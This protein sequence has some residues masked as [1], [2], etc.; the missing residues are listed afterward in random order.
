MMLLGKPE[1]LKH[2]LF[3]PTNSPTEVHEMHNRMQ[4]L[5]NLLQ[6]KK[7]F[8]SSFFIIAAISI[9]LFYSVEPVK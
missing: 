5:T 2:S 9:I 4:K 6:N 1:G 7:N 3:I 8:K